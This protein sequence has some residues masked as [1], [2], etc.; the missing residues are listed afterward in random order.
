MKKINDIFMNK[1]VPFLTKVGNNRYLAAIRDGI[2]ITIPFTIIGSI[3]MII[4]NLPITGWD[5]IIKPYSS[6][7]NAAT[8]TTFGIIGLI[9]A[10][11]LGYFFSKMHNI[12]RITGTIISLVCFLLAT[13]NDKFTI[14]IDNFG[15][16][17][18]FSAII[19]SLITIEIVEFFTSKKNCY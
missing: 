18:L 12:D 13:L 17:G 7:L 4:G 16:T 15:S 9:G 1:F 2:S 6:M 8:N 10:I 14:N 19:V 3:F 11:S 5:K